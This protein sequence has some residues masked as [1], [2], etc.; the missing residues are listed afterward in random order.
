M[1]ERSLGLY[2]SQ[3]VYCSRISLYDRYSYC[4]SVLCKCVNDLF[5]PAVRDGKKDDDAECC[6]SE[7]LPAAFC[8]SS[9]VHDV[10]TR[11][12]RQRHAATGLVASKDDV[13]TKPEVDNVLQSRQRRI[14][15]RPRAARTENMITFGRAVLEI[16]TQRDRQ[17]CSSQYT[18]TL[19][20]GVI[21]CVDYLCLR[22]R[23]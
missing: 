1:E 23:R 22:E 14:E 4:R 17:T 11:S 16:S 2:N 3:E 9:R 13:S 10:A 21:T 6:Y 15:P 20:D 19:R 5:S 7:L 12:R 18:A 8:C